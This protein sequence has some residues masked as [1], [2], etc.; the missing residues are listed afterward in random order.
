M[1]VAGAKRDTG[2][3]TWGNAAAS[4]RVCSCFGE[5]ITSALG[6]SSTIWPSYITAMRLQ[7]A[8]STDR[9]WLIMIRPMSCS[10]T[11]RESRSRTW[12]WTMTSRA[13]VGSSAM[14]SR[15]EQARAIAIMTRCFCPPESSWG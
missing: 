12:A 8:A 2:S 5:P 13:V 3:P 14:I 9:S 1:L 15:G 7:V 4:A 11:S 6:P 10:A